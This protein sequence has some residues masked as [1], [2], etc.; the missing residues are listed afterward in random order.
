[1]KH[2]RYFT[3]QNTFIVMNLLQLEFKQKHTLFCEYLATNMM[4]VFKFYPTI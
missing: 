3:Y 1:M 2:G 4:H